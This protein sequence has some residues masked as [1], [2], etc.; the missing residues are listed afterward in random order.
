M[1]MSLVTDQSH[2]DALRPAAATL[3]NGLTFKDGK[4]YADFDS[5]T[6]H[7]AEFGLA[8]LIAGVAAKKLGLL[9]LAVAFVV[10]F[11]KGIVVGGAGLLLAVRKKLGLQKE[12]PPAP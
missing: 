8:A 5:S 7:V 12:P 11:A 1:S 4:R 10:K 6:D 2:I 3:L 9:A